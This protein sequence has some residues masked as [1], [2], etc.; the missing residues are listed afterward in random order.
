MKTPEIKLEQAI[1]QSQQLSTAPVV[2]V[3][4]QSQ[5]ISE[6]PLKPSDQLGLLLALADEYLNA[7]HAHTTELSLLKKEAH[8]K[9]YFKLVATGLTCLEAVLKVRRRPFT[10]CS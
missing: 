4:Q 3:K 1:E 9:Q 8:L 7:A 6:K 10:L 5:A 2:N